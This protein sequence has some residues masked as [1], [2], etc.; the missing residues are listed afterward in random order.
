MRPGR[1]VFRYNKVKYSNEGNVM[2]LVINTNTNTCRFYGYCK[3]SAQLTLLKELLHSESKLKNQDLVTDK[4]GRY[5]SSA[6]G[7][8]GAYSQRTDPKAIEIDN[9]AREIGRDLDAARIAG[10]YEKLITI[11]DSHMTGLLFQHVDKHVK[12]WIRNRIQKDL[13]HLTEP[14]LLEYLQTHAQFADA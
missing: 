8:S 4:Q 5:M 12:E 1:L 13:I 10:T 9:F 7:G 14:Q 6:V 3:K 11:A 2:I